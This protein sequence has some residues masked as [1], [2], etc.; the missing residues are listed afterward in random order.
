MAYYAGIDVGSLAT[1]CVVINDA[2]RA[3]AKAA[4]PTGVAGA[5]AAEEAR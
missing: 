1:K 5:V 4:L 2:G 3:A